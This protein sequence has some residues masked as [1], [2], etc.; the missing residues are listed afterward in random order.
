MSSLLEAAPRL[1]KDRQRI[2]VAVSGGVDSMVLLHLLQR[3]REEFHWQLHLAHLNHCLRGR[4]SDADEQLVRRTAERLNI[5]GSTG[6]ADVLAIAASRKV[7]TEMAARQAR[8]E[9]LARIAR[10]E[11][12]STI[13]LAHH[14]DDQAELFFLRLLRGSSPEGL[15]GMASISPSPV[16]PALSLARPLLNFTKAQ[17]LEYA[18]GERIVF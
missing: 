2:L 7:S 11:G 12:I 3:G 17:L 14:A 10:Q 5:P 1:F 8:H 9:F 4:S 6:R 18:R 16:D 13:A 15:A